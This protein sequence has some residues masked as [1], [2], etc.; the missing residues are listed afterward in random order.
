MR[1]IILGLIS[2]FLI[3][4]GVWLYFAWKYSPINKVERALQNEDYREVVALYGELTKQEDQNYVEEELLSQAEKIYQDY[5]TEKISYEEMDAYYSMVSE[6]ILKKNKTV[7][8]ERDEMEEIR[9]SREIYDK[10]VSLMEQGEYLEAITY[11]EQV[12]TKDKAYR[13][14]ADNAI[15][16]CQEAYLNSILERIDQLM[17]QEEYEAAREYI[18]EAMKSMPEEESLSEKLREVQKY[19]DINIDGT[20][21]TT[22]DFGDLIAKELG[23]YNYKVTFPAQMVFELK[24]HQMK[25]SVSRD[26]IK[27]ALEALTGDAGSMEAIYSVAQDYGFDKKT[28]DLLVAFTYGGSYAD[29]IMDNFGSEIDAALAE[30]CY[31]TSFGVD[32]SKIYIGTTGKNDRNYFTY[33]FEG[34]TLTV[35]SYTGAGNILS[36]MKYP[37][38]FKRK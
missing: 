6:E 5:V 17:Q 34:S 15:W 11:F 30:Y 27:P 13:Q 20:W 31:E 2:V 21:C 7:T 4:G 37:M 25:V 14:K 26:S 33:T 24:D 1:K 9:S 3:A 23:V 38:I 35:E 28:A 10:A 32:K 8:A 36:L 18:L 12:S 22:Y 19:L 16:E 29:F